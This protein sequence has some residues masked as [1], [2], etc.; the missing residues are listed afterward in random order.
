MVNRFVLLA[1][2][3]V[4][5]CLSAYEL[6]RRGPEWWNGLRGWVERCRCEQANPGRFN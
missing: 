6:D 5:A 4:L 2:L 1:L 3:A